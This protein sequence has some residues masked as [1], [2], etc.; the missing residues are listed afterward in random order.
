DD[1]EMEGVLT[2]GTIEHAAIESLRAGADMFLVCHWEEL[3]WRAW[4]AVLS[5]AER[6]KKF[7]R[8][9]TEAADRVLRA[10]QKFARELKAVAD[11]PTEKT[12][13]K[14]RERV[15]RFSEEVQRARRDEAWW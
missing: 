2:V 7:E 9:V 15:L 14:L 8:R 6:D 1:L 12:I 10:K 3:V 5:L 13:A 4:E 11:P